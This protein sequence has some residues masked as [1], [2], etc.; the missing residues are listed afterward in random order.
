MGHA[1]LRPVL[2]HALM[3]A[4]AL[5]L[6]AIFL[7]ACVRQA[8]Q[9]LNAQPPSAQVI[10]ISVVHATMADANVRQAGWE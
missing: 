4:L 2:H 9:I 3:G 5:R 10:A 6:V 1:P 8:S 7:V